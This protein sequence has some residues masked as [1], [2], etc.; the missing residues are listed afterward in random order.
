MA[1]C[2][3]KVTR[4]VAFFACFVAFMPC[5]TSCQF[6]A[7]SPA[8]PVLTLNQS[9]SME[10]EDCTHPIFVCH[11]KRC[12]DAPFPVPASLP[13]GYLNDQNPGSKAQ[14]Y[15]DVCKYVAGDIGPEG[16]GKLTQF[17]VA[18]C[19]DSDGC[20]LYR[21]F[22]QPLAE[23]SGRNAAY[24]CG[25]SWSPPTSTEGRS[26]EKYFEDAGVCTHEYAPCPALNE[27]KTSPGNVGGYL[28]KCLAPYGHPFTMGPTQSANCIAEDST[29]YTLP[30]N[31]GMQVFWGNDYDF[32][33]N[34]EYCEIQKSEDGTY[35]DVTACDESSKRSVTLNPTICA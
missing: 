11:D 29:T 12:A 5:K 27:T 26:L 25:H 22:D 14:S 9:L 24:G 31:A 23:I 18:T 35:P 10:E 21:V 6:L 15:D 1:Q 20:P 8:P 33:Q 30:A 3:S 19:S 32:E 28:L 34:C 17:T 13:Y 7:P 16:C 2:D 4:P